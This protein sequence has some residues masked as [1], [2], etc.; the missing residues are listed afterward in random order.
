MV[1]SNEMTVRDLSEELDIKGSTLRRR[2][3]EYKEM[4]DNAFLGN[5]SLEIDKGHEIVEL[6]KRVEGLE[7]ENELLKKS[8]PF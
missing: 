5:G 7:Y 2:P 8:G 1:P 4:G 3:C 6:R